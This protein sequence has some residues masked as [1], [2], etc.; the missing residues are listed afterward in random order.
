MPFLRTKSKSD[1]NVSE[2]LEAVKLDSQGNAIGTVYS[3][4][5]SNTAQRKMDAV[6]AYLSGTRVYDFTGDVDFY[7]LDGNA[8]VNANGQGRPLFTHTE[9]ILYLS[10]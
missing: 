2:T 5:Y 1:A 7:Y 4:L 8:L 3:P 6:N 9:Q 10:R